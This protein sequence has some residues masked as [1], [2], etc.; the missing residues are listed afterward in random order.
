MKLIITYHA[1][2]RLNERGIS[3]ENIK[4]TINSPDFLEILL[5]GKIRARKYF[6]VKIL[7]VIYVKSGKEF[8][9]LSSY[10]L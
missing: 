7:A 5:S 9:I 6:G 4:K 10:Y 8:V 2:F 1:Q 3:I